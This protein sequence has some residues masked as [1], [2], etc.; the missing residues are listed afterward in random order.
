MR[1]FSMVS[2]HWKASPLDSRLHS[3]SSTFF[4]PDSWCLCFS[5]YFSLFLLLTV[6]CWASLLPPGLTS[7]WIFLKNWISSSSDSIFLS[8]SRRAM[9]ASSASWDGKRT[10][11]TPESTSQQ[12]PVLSSLSLWGSGKQ[13][14]AVE[15]K[16]R[17][18][19]WVGR[20]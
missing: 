1:A 5:D 6:T 3:F 7:S 16:F 15:V 2:R 19:V 4:L 10:F 11:L 8:R 20:H 14:I 12:P 18:C 17:D 13:A 9:V